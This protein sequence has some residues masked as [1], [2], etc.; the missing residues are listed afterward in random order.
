MMISAGFRSSLNK[1]HLGYFSS[2]GNVAAFHNVK[3]PI[4][5]SN[6]AISS[7]LLNISYG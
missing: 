3:V 4:K 6:V 2:R 7:E 1:V 5:E